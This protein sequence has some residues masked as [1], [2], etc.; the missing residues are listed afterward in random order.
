[1]DVISKTM[2]AKKKKVSI[3][4]AC[5]EILL[6][7]LCCVIGQTHLLPNKVLSTML[8]PKSYPPRDSCY[9]LFCCTPTMLI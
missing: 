1:M 5:V 9:K 8:S 4:F 2:V 6:E 3:Y 7:Y